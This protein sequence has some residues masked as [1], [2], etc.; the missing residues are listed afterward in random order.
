MCLQMATKHFAFFSV[1]FTDFRVLQAPVPS[2]YLFSTSG[3]TTGK[4]TNVLSD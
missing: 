3:Q 4:A 2:V 1:F